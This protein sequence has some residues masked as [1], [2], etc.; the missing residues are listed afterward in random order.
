MSSLSKKNF[1]QPDD[2]MH[3]AGKVTSEVVE[4]NGKT[5]YRVTAQPGWRWT[6]D[7]KP[8]LKTDS[9]QM[10]HLLYMLSGS[11]GVRMNDGQELEYGPGDIAAIPPGHDGWGLGDEPTVWIELPH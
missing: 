3:P 4:L 6:V 1:D 10:D 8:V 5:L 9:C 2:T 7:L 11:M